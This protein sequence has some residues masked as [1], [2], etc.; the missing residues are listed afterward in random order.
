[1]TPEAPEIPKVSFASAS[2]EEARQNESMNAFMK[3]VGMHSEHPDV[4]TRVVSDPPVL[5]I[6]IMPIRPAKS[7]TLLAIFA[8]SSWNV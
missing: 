1:M 4:S 7:P 3:D 6:T 8:T 5:I 2:T